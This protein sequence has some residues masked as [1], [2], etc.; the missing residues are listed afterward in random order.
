[1][2]SDIH[3][4]RRMCAVFRTWRPALVRQFHAKPVMTGTRAARRITRTA[5]LCSH[6]RITPV[7]RITG[8]RVC[9]IAN[10]ALDSDRP[11]RCA[12]CPAPQ[13]SVSGQIG[14]AVNCEERT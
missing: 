9:K 2:G 13:P 1:L 14:V 11:T 7:S 6:S 3:A 5:L 10:H 4:F 8:S 12:A